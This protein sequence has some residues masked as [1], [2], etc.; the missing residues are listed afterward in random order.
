[1]QHGQ[2][3]RTQF[4]P[5][6]NG[7]FDEQ[8]LQDYASSLGPLG[9][10]TSFTANPPSERGGFTHRIF[11]VAFA[12]GKSVIINSYETHDGKYEQFLVAPAS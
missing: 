3:D 10:P 9:A 6:C 5:D 7:Y 4:T 12:S 11:R 2:I 8:A 1:L